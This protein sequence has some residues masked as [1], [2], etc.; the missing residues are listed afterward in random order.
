[1]IAEEF[2]RVGRLRFAIQSRFARAQKQRIPVT[3]PGSG[4]AVPA[5]PLDAVIRLL[6]VD[7]MKVHPKNRCCWQGR[8]E[9]EASFF[10][11]PGPE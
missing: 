1:M 5:S 3:S 7:R 8:S 6:S 11:F 9:S 2:S 4:V 10:S